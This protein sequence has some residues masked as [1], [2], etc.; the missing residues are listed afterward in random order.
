MDAFAMPEVT[1]EGEVFDCVISAVNGHSGYIAVVPGNKSRK[2]DKKDNRGVGQQAKTVARAM[3][4]LW[5]TVFDVPAVICT[6]RGR[7]FV[8][9]WCRTMCKYM[10]VRNAKM[11]HITAVR[12]EERRWLAGNCS[13]KSGNCIFRSS[14]EIG[15]IPFREFCR[16]T[17]IYP[18]RLVC[19]PVAF[20]SSGI[21]L[22]VLSRE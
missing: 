17:T 22:H 14:A 1:V 8:G 7:Q 20:Y 15:I 11:V 12:T 18:N 16:H 4:R 3:I 13:K 10:G 6:D 19:P 2:K 9:A 5:L 21:E